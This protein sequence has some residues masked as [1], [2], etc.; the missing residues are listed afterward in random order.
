MTATPRSTIRSLFAGRSSVLPAYIV[1]PF[2]LVV[3]ALAAL[4]YHSYRLSVRTERGVA[5]LS[6]QY[7]HHAAEI[8]A[9]RA[10]AAVD[11]EVFRAAD[12]WQQIERTSRPTRESLEQW[13]G[14]NPWIVSALYV[15]DA[16]PSEAVFVIQELEIEPTRTFRNEFF[17][18]TGAIRYSYDPSR[19]LPV[20]RG[21]I[22][23]EAQVHMAHLPDALEVRRRTQIG[24]VRRGPRVGRVETPVGPAVVVPLTPPLDD[25]AVQAYI[26]PPFLESWLEDPRLVSL[27]FAVLAIAVVT[28]GA[29]FALR[30]LRR[31]SDAMQLRSALIANISHELRTPLSMIRMGAETLKRGKRLPEKDRDDIQES[32]HREVVHLS[33][34]VENVLDVARLSKSARPLVF[35]PIDPADLV[36]SLVASYES[37][38]RS[39]GF[40]LELEIEG[41]PG[42]QQWDREAVSRALLNLIDNAMKYSGDDRRLKIR[43]SDDDEFVTIAVEDRGIG[44]SPQDLSRIFEPY[45]RAQFSDTQTRRG[46]G[47]GLTLVQ[48]IVESHGGR[49]EVESVRGT[50]STFMLRFPKPETRPE[51]VRNLRTREA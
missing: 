1:L 20:V 43:L 21:A 31:E 26:D 11:A 50:G 46:A 10:D 22:E 47:L 24:V 27:A 44:I 51:P 19:L 36:R 29:A 7:L 35:A 48:Q 28:V 40:D 30:G 14:H 33:H 39:K 41:H 9:T 3:G 34:L 13:L 12:D 23:Q 45:Y 6:V 25:Y 49:V 32:I 37:W 17:T 16:D 18:A 15:P 5:T 4:S 38:I 42:E 2:V 8:S